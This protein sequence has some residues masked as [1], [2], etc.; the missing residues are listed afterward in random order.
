M[1]SKQKMNK[2]KIRVGF[3]KGERSIDTSKKKPNS[4]NK[5]FKPNH[6]EP[7]K[8]NVHS[9]ENKRMLFRFNSYIYGYYFYFNKFGH[10]VSTS[11]FMTSR[12]PRFGH[13]KYFGFVNHVRCFECNTLG[14]T[15]KQCKVHLHDKQ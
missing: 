11:R 3:E 12:M 15:V 4:T 2:D 7:S 5:S 8:N 1:L 10:K 13:K 6:Y 14:N 9:F